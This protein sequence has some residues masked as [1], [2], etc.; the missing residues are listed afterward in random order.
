MKTML[1]QWITPRSTR[2]KHLPFKS[3]HALATLAFLL[4]GALQETQAVTLVENG[5]ARASIVLPD[6][7]S[8]AARR[9]AAM[10][11]SHLK[12]ISGAEIAQVVE[13]KLDPA[14]PQAL[15]LVGESRLAKAHGMSCD[16]LGAGGFH[17]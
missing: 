11:A 10:L 17:A 15:I 9:A 6:T 16:G 2:W 3:C 5:S 14:T 7:P 12:Q 4:G 13:S 1:T 8:P